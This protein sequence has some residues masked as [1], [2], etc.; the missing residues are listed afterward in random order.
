MGHLVDARSERQDEDLVLPWFD[1]HP[2]GIAHPEP[3]LGNLGHLLPALADGVLVVENIALHLQVGPA[4]SWRAS[5]RSSLLLRILVSPSF[6]VRCCQLILHISVP[7]QCFH[8]RRSVN[9]ARLAS[10]LLLCAPPQESDSPGH[11]TN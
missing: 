3:F 8:R 9:L 4:L 10:N 7:A 11:A 2:V 5:R 6:K 1:L